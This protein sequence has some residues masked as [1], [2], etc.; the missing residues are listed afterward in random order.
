MVDE[1]AVL[2]LRSN[3][4]DE[5]ADL[6]PVGCRDHPFSAVG[7]GKV[8]RDS[9]NLDLGIRGTDLGGGLVERRLRAGYQ[10]RADAAVGEF[11]SE[12][13]ADAL[14]SPDHNGPR[15]IFLGKCRGI[16]HADS[17]VDNS[18]G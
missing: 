9:A 2:G 11:V 13:R 17:F 14:G 8:H 7:N 1:V 15:P 18:Y 12:C 5:R 6:E 10:H 3:V 16:R 4:V